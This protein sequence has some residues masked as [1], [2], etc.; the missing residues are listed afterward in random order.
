MA[1]I[2]RRKQKDGTFSYR[3]R[4]RKG[5][6]EESNSFQRRRD[7]ET[8]ARQLEGVADQ[9]PWS[10]RVQRARPFRRLLAAEPADL[11]GGPSKEA[12]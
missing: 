6:Y 1:V 7:A 3:A 8:W 9:L 11:S 5:G 2:E 10:V 4:V 12:T